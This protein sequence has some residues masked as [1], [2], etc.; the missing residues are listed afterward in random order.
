MRSS[1]ITVYQSAQTKHANKEEIMDKLMTVQEAANWLGCTAHTIY[2][3]ASSRE[4]TSHKVCGRIKFYEADL[5][6]YVESTRR[7][8][9]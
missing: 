1:C 5:L 4:I 3:K 9:V 7:E 6:A 2:Q 8:A